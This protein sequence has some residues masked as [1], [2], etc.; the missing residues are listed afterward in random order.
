MA[1]LY[2]EGGGWFGRVSGHARVRGAGCRVSGRVQG[3]GSPGGFGTSSSARRDRELGPEAFAETVR[4][5]E[6]LPRAVDAVHSP[7]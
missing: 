3:A 2:M 1:T 5:R 7:P 4:V 6:R